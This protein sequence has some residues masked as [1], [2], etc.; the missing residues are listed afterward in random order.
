MIVICPE[1][2]SAIEIIDERDKVICPVC[3]KKFTIDKS[4]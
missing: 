4:G 2:E 3:G 1:C